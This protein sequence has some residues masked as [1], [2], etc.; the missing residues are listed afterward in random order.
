MLRAISTIFSFTTSISSPIDPVVSSANATSMRGELD[1]ARVRSS[2]PSMGLDLLP[3]RTPAGAEGS[4]EPRFRSGIAP[5]RNARLT[6]APR[7]LGFIEQGVRHG[8][9][10]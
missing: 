3:R 6:W 2:A 5:L 8:A 4:D 9:H 10:A 1:A 7:R